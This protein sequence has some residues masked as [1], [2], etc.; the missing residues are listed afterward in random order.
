M[1]VRIGK[2]ERQIER[3]STA[4]AKGGGNRKVEGKDGKERKRDRREK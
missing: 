3:T 2:R 1:K 4:K